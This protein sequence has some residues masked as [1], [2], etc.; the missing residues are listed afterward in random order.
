MNESS[1]SYTP[2]A[3]P[4]IG[5]SLSLFEVMMYR[6]RNETQSLIGFMKIVQFPERRMKQSP[7]S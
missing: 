6:T 1:D 3:L 4:S 5:R 2:G 7:D